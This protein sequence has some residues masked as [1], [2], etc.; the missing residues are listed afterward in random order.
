VVT[1]Y[2]GNGVVLSPQALIEEMDELERVGADVAA[3]LRISEACP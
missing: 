1:C 2:I 3:R